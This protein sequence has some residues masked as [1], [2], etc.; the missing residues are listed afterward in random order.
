MKN[1]TDI[2]SKEHT[3]SDLTPFSSSLDGFAKKLLG[4]Q[5]FVLID[6]LKSWKNI[7][8]EELALES[9][10]ERI[11]FKKDRQ[12]GG[13]L[14]VSTT[15]GA[16][17]LELQHKSQIIIEKINTYFGYKAIDKLKI[18]QNTQ[19]EQSQNINIADIEK[20]KLVTKDEQNY[21]NDI[22]KDIEDETLKQKLQSLLQTAFSAQKQE[23]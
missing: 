15:S 2:L 4:K 23:N 22:T 20:K 11:D 3:L 16:Y 7:A 9:L 13:T 14:V 12:D 21:I 18:V 17:A 10:P 5:G 1:K 8:G 6:L 19:I